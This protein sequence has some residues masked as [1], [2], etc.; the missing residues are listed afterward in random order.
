M[1]K[2]E[3]IA[4]LSTFGQEADTCGLCDGSGWRM[5]S[6]PVGSELKKRECPDCRERKTQAIT[7][8]EQLCRERDA[9]LALNRQCICTYCG[10]VDTIPEGE[11]RTAGLRRIM[12]AHIENCPQHPLK[13]IAEIVDPIQKERDDLRAQ[14]TGAWKEA[15]EAGETIGIFPVKTTSLDALICGIK[16]KAEELQEQREADVKRLDWL[17]SNLSH[18]SRYLT[19]YDQ[20]RAPKNL[21]EAIDAAM[22]E[23]NGKVS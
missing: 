2:D 19:I 17:Q 8:I 22:K 3:I 21:R 23:E 20:S 7:A 12:V 10:Q 15:R 4:L 5:V 11:D 1:T 6:W 18:L 13:R 16:D 14:L 9:A